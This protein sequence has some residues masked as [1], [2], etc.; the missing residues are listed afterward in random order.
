MLIITSGAFEVRPCHGTVAANKKFPFRF[1]GTAVQRFA[2][3]KKTV[4]RLSASLKLRCL[5]ATVCEPT[6]DV[7]LGEVLVVLKNNNVARAPMAKRLSNYLF[8][9][10]AKRCAGVPRKRNGNFLLAATVQDRIESVT[11]YYLFPEV[12]SGK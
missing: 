7:V 10:S 5:R 1:R 3:D 8:L 6:V 11:I 12:N 9:S 2:M 4:I